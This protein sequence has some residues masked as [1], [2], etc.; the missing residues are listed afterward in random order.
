VRGIPAIPQPLRILLVGSPSRITLGVITHELGLGGHLARRLARELERPVE[1]TVTA[2]ESPIARLRPT[3]RGLRGFDVVVLALGDRELGEH[4]RP[5][6]VQRDLELLLEQLASEPT[7]IETFVLSLPAAG[8][9]SATEGVSVRDIRRSTDNIQFNS[10]LEAAAVSTGSA[11]WVPFAPCP[12]ADAARDR[13]RV[14]SSRTYDRWAALIV[15]AL[16]STLAADRRRRAANDLGFRP[17][18]TLE[19]RPNLPLAV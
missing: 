12:W 3:L 17:V 1:L 9:A 13:S 5:A 8:T 18:V 7:A 15:P 10:A 4:R 14:R 16:V 2:T 11:T 19:R 6:A